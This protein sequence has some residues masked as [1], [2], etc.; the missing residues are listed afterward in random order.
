MNSVWKMF[1]AGKA[2]NVLG[3]VVGV[4]LFSLSLFSQGSYGRILGAVTDQ[5]GGVIAGATV[6]I[7]DKDRGV[8]RTLTTDDAGAYN[9]PTL[10][11]GTYTVRVEAKGFQT[12]NRENVVLEV[13]KEVRVDL[14]P[15][16]GSQSQSVTVTEAMPLVET[17]NATLGGTLENAD[18]NDMPLNGRN[19][20]NLLSLRP[21]VMV[22]PGGSPWSQSTNNTR[23]DET[24]WMMDGVI[25]ASFYDDRPVGNAPS[26]FTDAATIV[27]VDAIQEF[28]LEENP[29]AEYGWKPGAVVNV[30]IKSGTNTLHGSAYAFGRT[31]GWD[32]R[33]FFTPAEVNGVCLQNT[34]FPAQCDKLPVQ[35]KQFGAVVGGPIKKDKLFFMAGYEGL[36]SLIGNIF[37]FPLPET[38]TGGG[39]INSMP[40]AINAIQ[41]NSSYKGLCNGTNGPVCLS[42]GSLNLLGCTG[43]PTT[44]GSYS[45]TGGLISN[46][47]S[48]TTGYAS[49]FPNVNRNDN[50]ITKLDYVINSKNRIA[51]MLW[52]GYYEATGQD[53]P[54]VNPLFASGIFIRSWSNVESWIWTPSS[55]VVNEVR[56]GYDRETQGF[57][58]GDA[59]FIPDGTGGLCTPA[60]CG[61]THYPINS[62]VTVGGG[63][64][65]ISIA[66]FSGG[67][68][69]LGNPNGTR[70]GVTG[71]GPYFDFQDNLS[72]LRGNHAL[73][74]GGELTHIEAD[75]FNTDFR[76]VDVNFNGG[77][78]TGLTDCTISNKPA[79]CPLED[80]F[81]G[82]PNVGSVL[83][84]DGTR[85]LVWW[86]YAGFAQDDWRI[87]PRLM[88][89]LGLRYEYEQ[90]IRE[91]NNLLGSFDPNS[92][93]GIVQQGQ[94][95]VGPTLY[96]PNYKE[97]SPRAGFAWDVTGKGTTVVR[98]GANVMYTT[99]FARAFMDNGPP[100]GSL[101]NAAEDPSAALLVSPNPLSGF[102]ACAS[103][104]TGQFCHQG[105]GTINL[106]QATFLAPPSTG[107]PV[108]QACLG[109][110]NSVIY[111][112]GTLTCSAAAPCPLYGMSLNLKTPYIVSYNFGV[113]H[114]FGPNLSLDVSYV[115]NHGYDLLALSDVNQC[116]PNV[117]PTQCASGASR[118]NFAKFPYLQIIN[119]QT[120]AAFS[121]YNSL[122]VTLTQRTSHGLDFTL[123]YTYGHGLDN[124]SLNFQGLPPQ[125]SQDQAAEYGSSDFDI[126][127][128]LTVTAS[129]AIPGK[130][131]FGQLLEGWKL[132][133]IVTVQTPQPWLVFD[134]SGAQDF[135][136][137]S[138]GFGDL[139]DRWNITGNPA[140]FRS[141]PDS[142]PFCGVDPNLPAG[143]AF[144]TSTI[145]CS[146][147]S[148][149][150]TTSTTLPSSLGAKCITADAA[151]SNPSTH[152][153][154]LATAGCYV[155]ANGNS[156]LTPNAL[157]T[158][159]NIGRNIFRD[160]GF[161]NVDF[162]VFKSFT[163][164][165]RF[166][167]EFRWEIFN[168]F[169]HPIFANPY[170]S[171][172][173]SF[174]GADLSKSATFGCGCS[175][176]DVAA[177]NPLIGSG[178]SR[179]MQLGLKLTF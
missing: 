145:I 2:I 15:L 169:N 10:I 28:N 164:K 33:N 8:A 139:T 161:K 27:P 12:L 16:P 76:G 46:P 153:S 119:M 87:K 58:I 4:L 173:T 19:Y 64:P 52:V 56:F 48:N 7:I 5:S 32:A 156:V 140:D 102:T 50:G 141:G 66:G 79:S 157:G 131:G 57:T 138:S 112:Q 151:Y 82:N 103:P 179:V 100:N 78:T 142:I 109:W 88:L 146:T 21:G 43:T 67:G 89:N 155:S 40:D 113:E 35:L 51:G 175:T 30:G 126:R 134:G 45:C 71:P 178:S 29:K 61:G 14:T 132:N 68:G 38:A 111:P 177:G 13:G 83:V 1:R 81:A 160:S 85:K 171:S 41:S 18:I 106:A 147:T 26:A 116:V 84:G 162:S 123:G 152:P 47:P 176:P 96:K 54:T 122:Q 24:A 73:K 168:L 98:G 149:A 17:T 128:R 20:Q 148:G 93:Y 23:P 127:H 90:P 166:G 174:L 159:G 115:G 91:V 95:G 39:A 158:F 120:N 114:S 99:L 101:G 117:D 36:R 44:V 154:T 172:N 94:A 129:Y 60:G 133:T 11:P 108:G 124:G 72:Y 125:N 143:T 80:F 42:Q 74:F 22:Q 69:G 55:T 25:N 130:K 107:C 150:Y 136:T 34:S 92:Q 65:N 49:T 86:H 63:L 110:N 163:F 9:A 31:D 53:H 59:N 97:F 167:A 70:P 3:A 75:Q 135:S 165:E 105:T 104:Y 6:T 62:G 37:I 144:T 77:L 170:G 121:N 137:G 118:P